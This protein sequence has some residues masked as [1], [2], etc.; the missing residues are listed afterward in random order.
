[1]SIFRIHRDAQTDTLAAFFSLKEEMLFIFYQSSF[2][3]ICLTIVF[4]PV[5][6]IL[7]A[8]LGKTKLFN[9]EKNKMGNV[10]KILIA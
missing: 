10:W 8:I 9:S 2:Y 3:S 1:M 7:E 4:V 5:L 6:I